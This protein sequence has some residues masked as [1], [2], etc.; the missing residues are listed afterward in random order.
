MA[1]RIN[2]AIKAIIQKPI[3]QYEHKD[4][5]HVNNPHFGLVDAPTGNGGYKKKTYQYDLQ[6]DP[7][8]Q[9][10]EKAERTNFDVPTATLVGSHINIF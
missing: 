8:L 1:K 5:Q 9:W 4:K 10:P 7:Q 2:K 3:E 6:L